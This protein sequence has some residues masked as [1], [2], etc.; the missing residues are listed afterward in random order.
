MYK[1]YFDWIIRPVVEVTY[2]SRNYWVYQLSNMMML[3]N[4]LRKRIVL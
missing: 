2:L 3:S 4:V 1:E